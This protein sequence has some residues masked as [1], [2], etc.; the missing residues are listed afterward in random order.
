MTSGTVGFLLLALLSAATL[1]SCNLEGDALIA[2]R[3][4]WSDPNNVLASWDPTL[5]NPCTWFHVTCNIDNSVIRVDLGNA[6]LSGT[7][8]P[9]LGLLRNLQYLE[10]YGNQISGGIPPELGNLRELV[11]L[12]LYENKLSGSIPVS[13]GNLKKL[14]F[15]RLQ[16]NKLSGRLPIEV[17]DLV[18]LGNLSIMNISANYMEG[19]IRQ[20]SRKGFAI[21]MIVQDYT[22]HK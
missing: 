11:S 8:V 14:R 17:L 10:L 21:T 6:G 18:R 15:M 5:V 3:S 22:V 4:A 9:Q 19:P 16:S 7:L 12:D 1:A 2:Q 20:S 13:L